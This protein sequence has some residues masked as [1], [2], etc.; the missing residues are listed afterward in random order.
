MIT[1]LRSVGLAAGLLAL[2][3]ASGC[4]SLAAPGRHGDAPRA[5]PEPSLA[6][7]WEG[8]IWETPSDNYQGVRRVTV[9]IAEDGA[10]TARIRDAECASGIA[11][12]RHHLVILDNRAPAGTSC[13]PQSLALAG[14]RMWGEFST[15]FNRRATTAALDLVRVRDREPA[16]TRAASP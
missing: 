9:S 4:A 2:V 1:D 16:T 5:T 6:G 10:W 11:T 3:A 8:Q 12:V 13:M 15:T 14:G 7:V